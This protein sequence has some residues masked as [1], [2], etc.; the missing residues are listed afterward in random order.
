MAQVGDE[1]DGKHKDKSLGGFFS[2]LRGRGH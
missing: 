1:H 2:S